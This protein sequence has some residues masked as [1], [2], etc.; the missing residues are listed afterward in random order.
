VTPSG[1][2]LSKSAVTLAL[3]T[4]RWFRF[5]AFLVSACELLDLLLTFAL[6]LG[7]VLGVV[8]E[9]FSPDAALALLLSKASLTTTTGID[10]WW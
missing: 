8:F 1:R 5:L 6:L 9:K 2:F 7:V 3:V 4:L 10:Y